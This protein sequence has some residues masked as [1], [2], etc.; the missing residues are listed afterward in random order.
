[1][2][3]NKKSNNNKII[4]ITGP[5]ATGKTKLSVELAKL[6]DGEIINADSTQVYKEMD[7]GTAKVT[8]SE[9]ENIPHHLFDIKKVTDNYTIYDYQKDCRKKINEIMKRGKTPI[10][11]GGTGLY[12]KAA[13]Y[14]Y[15]FK[16]EEYY[17]EYNDLTNEEILEKIKEVENTDIHVNNRKRLVRELNKINNNSLSTGK[18]NEKLYDFITIG[19]TTDRDNLY[20]RINK[21]VDSMLKDGLLGEAK[22]F[23]D[24]KLNTKAINTPICYKEL[25][26]YFNKEI[27][28]DDALDLIRKR[29][30]NY[31]KR[32]YTFF[33]HQMDVK[34]FDVNY[35]DFNKTIKEVYNY[36][37]NS[38]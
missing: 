36:I 19:L 14:N 32:Q 12:I 9:K 16:D 27:S 7:I 17:S 22:Y 10:L 21:R 34:W 38:K 28:L 18:A 4:V 8:K 6:L 33:K 30:R 11:V 20:N 15:E 1:M 35:D 25:F 29:S 13:L 3:K 24:M 31:A 23:Y 37:E 5:T 26:M 2:E